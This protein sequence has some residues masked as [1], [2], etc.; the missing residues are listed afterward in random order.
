MRVLSLGM[1]GISKAL[2]EAGVWATREGAETMIAAMENGLSPYRRMRM[3]LRP[4]PFELP[5]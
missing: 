4:W 3:E 5:A 2:P 1:C